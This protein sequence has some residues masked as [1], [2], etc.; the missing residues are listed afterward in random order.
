M[1]TPC[2]RVHSIVDTHTHTHAQSALMW[3]AKA[4]LQL[5]LPQK[6]TRHKSVRL[7]YI[8][9]LA[10]TRVYRDHAVSRTR[11]TYLCAHRNNACTRAHGAQTQLLIHQNWFAKYGAQY[12]SLSCAPASVC[13]C[14]NLCVCVR[15]SS[16]EAQAAPDRTSSET[17]KYAAFILAHSPSTCIRSRVLTTHE[18]V[19]GSFTK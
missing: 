6:H 18:C 10:D 1:F 16:R 8:A 3:T 11:R 7:A 19:L 5:Q 15:A 17:V 2:T 9:V 4:A 13:V 12:I 14:V